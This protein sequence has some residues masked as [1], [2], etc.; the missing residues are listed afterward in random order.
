[1]SFESGGRADKYGNQYENRYLAKLL[2][3]VLNEQL[4]SLQVEPLGPEGD[5]VE[6]I[7]IDA[8]GK[9]TYYQCK[10]SNTTHNSWSMYDL[11]THDVFRRS[12]KFVEGGTNHYYQFVSP[13]QYGELDELCQR[14]RTNSSAEDFIRYQ[15]T[16]QRLRD[17]FNDCAKYYELNPEDPPQLN[18]LVYILSHCYFEQVSSGQ[19]ALLDLNEHVGM[20]FAGKSDVARILLEQYANE[21]GKFGVIITAR[22][23][24]DH[25]KN[26]GIALRSWNLDDRILPRIDTLNSIYWGNYLPINN[27]LIHRSATDAVLKEIEGGHSVILCGKAGSGKSGC[28][29][30]VIEKL[31]VAHTLYLSIKLDKYTP[32]ASADEFGRNIGLPESPVFCLNNLSAEMPSV[33]ILDQL[34]SLRWTDKHSAVAL[35]VCKEMIAQVAAINRAK[36]GILSIV[37]VT[38]TF[39]FENDTGIKALFTNR[40]PERDIAWK[41]ITVDPLT[42]NEVEKIVGEQYALLSPRLKAL[43]RTPSSLYVWSQLAENA[44]TNSIASIDQLLTLWWDQLVQ[45]CVSSGLQLT[46]ITKCK[47]LLVSGVDRSSSFAMPVSLVTGYRPIINIL[48]SNGLL[49]CS[50][51][52]VSFAHQSFLDYFIIHKA[53]LE[54]CAD[55][56]SAVDIIGPQNEQ[57]PL[58]RYRVLSMLQGILDYDE[59]L[60]LEQCGKILLSDD[61]RYYFKCTVFEIIGQIDTPSQDVITLVE[62]YSS[63]PDWHEYVRQVVYYGHPPFIM[64]LNKESAEN[65]LSEEGLSLL[66]S[67]S[68][69]SPDYVTSILGPLALVNNETDQKIFW[70]LCHDANDD[71]DSMFVLRKKLLLHDP[72]LFRN[73]WGFGALFDTG[74]I[75]AVPLMCIILQSEAPQGINS[76]HFPDKKITV[77]YCNTNYALIV[78]ELLPEICRATAAFHPQWPHYDYS[79]EY[80]RWV[81]RE[82][83]EDAVRSVV[84]IVKI[85]L[86]RY[87]EVQPDEFF[88]QLSDLECTV[89]VVGHEIVSYAM[90]QLPTSCSDHAIQWLLSEFSANIFDYTGSEHD[91][92]ASCKRIIKKFSPWCTNRLFLELEHAICSWKDEPKR[93]V[94]IYQHRLETNQAKEY[95]PVYYAYWGHLQKAL[96]PEMAQ[97]RLSQ[98]AKDLIAV[99]NRNPWIRDPFYYSGITCG[100]VKSVVSPVY[101]SPEKISDKSW[102]NIIST[103]SSKMNG[104]WDRKEISEYY[105]EAT[106]DSFSSSFS[107]AAKKQPLRFAKLSLLFQEDCYQGYICAVINALDNDNAVEFVDIELTCQV[108]RRF[109]HYSD[110]NVA[111]A[112]ARLIRS[113]ASEEWP[114]DVV[115]I[116]SWIAIEHPEPKADEYPV[117][118]SDDPEHISPDSLI[119]NSINC[120]RGCALNAIAALLWEHHTL[121]IKLKDV[122]ETACSDMNVAVRFAVIPCALAYY[123]IDPNFSFN[124][125]RQLLE[126]DPRILAAPHAW[127]LLSRDYSNN[128]LEYRKLLFSACNSSV[129][130][131]ENQ[132]AGFVCA[133]AVF[134]ADEEMLKFAMTNEFTHGQADRMCIQAASSFNRDEYHSTSK[135]VLIHIIDS[136]T[137]ELNGLNR[138]FFDRC[139][140]IERDKDFLVHLMESCHSVR[141]IHA[142]LDYLNKSD[143]DISAFADILCAIGTSIADAP[144]E[145]NSRLI[146]SDL[147]QTVIRLYDRGSQ[148]PQIKSICL[149]IWDNLFRSNLQDIKPLSEMLDNFE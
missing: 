72:S 97:V 107:Q 96:L 31:K 76:L 113:R 125:F 116:L 64:R 57:T 144:S 124:I 37:F 30:E 137:G 142:F 67:I 15:L 21:S 85:A 5:G 145:W 16:N 8:C 10:A 73:F 54:I 117:T 87:A 77:A 82:Y 78:R 23:V 106:H 29:Q 122:V 1:M 143:E 93:M 126:K 61:V 63:Y 22:D 149:D 51:M 24:I 130:E 59:K 100:P 27:C 95:H 50:D 120:A 83:N 86:G 49:I 40:N 139:V 115:D 123:N 53:L 62:D 4:V 33:L 75:R 69:K 89:S 11:T 147:I 119:T 44:R 135:K 81:A 108:I 84:E 28:I 109:Y 55:E 105:V 60:F 101:K 34:D 66:K 118:S 42:N 20:L 102:I 138:L 3:R 14:A 19:E 98:P 41:T 65:W 2:L 6:Y 38:R 136:H 140:L 148:N 91:Y 70:A 114:D 121:G 128:V 127:E 17:T 129:D 58:V 36:E 12:K 25:M 88:G 133:I 7:S 43:L 26:R 9:K 141:L 111:I 99:L 104:R 110:S 132:A 112:L 103:P 90:E 71:S 74:S 39:D 134:H 80:R 68:H 35:D 131:L 32:I 45:L 48:I 92:L 52:R 146:V 13:L 18:Q 79:D 56:K 47:D 94:N 46:D